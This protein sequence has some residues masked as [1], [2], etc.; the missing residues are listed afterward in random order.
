G[1]AM[2][3]QNP[4]YMDGRVRQAISLAID[5][6]L[7]MTILYQ[8]LGQVMHAIPWLFVWDEQPT[9]ENGLLGPWTRYDPAEA[10]KLLSAAGAE[11]LEMVNIFFPYSSAY[12][13]TPDILTDMFRDVGITMTGGAADYTEFN[14]QWVGRMLE[15]VSTAGWGTIGFDAENYFYNSMHSTAPGNR[16]RFNDPKLDELTEA[17]QVELDPEARKLIFQEIWNYE[18]EKAYR[19]VIGGG[20]GFFVYQPWLR[21]IRFGGALSTTNIYQDWGDIIPFGWIDK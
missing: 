12:E 20:G 9:V 1:F 2:N 13:Q 11:G 15:D 6:D 5:R 7:L 21:G 4:K 18:L 14:S 16:W 17:Q 19:P 3:L 8:G 10:K